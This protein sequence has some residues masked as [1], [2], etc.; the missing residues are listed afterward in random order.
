MNDIEQ[1]H[2]DFAKRLQANDQSNTVECQYNI[3]LDIL[4]DWENSKWFWVRWF[5]KRFHTEL[6]RRI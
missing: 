5:A 2:Y 6:Q 4:F 3:C 1:F